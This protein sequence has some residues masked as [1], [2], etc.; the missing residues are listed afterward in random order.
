MKKEIN[1]GNENKK[2]NVNEEDYWN[3]ELDLLEINEG[4]LMVT[5]S[6]PFESKLSKMLVNHNKWY[7]HT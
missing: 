5:K 3:N 4:E 2:L 7:N 6:I 1:E